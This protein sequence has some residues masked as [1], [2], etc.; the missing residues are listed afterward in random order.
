MCTLTQFCYVAGLVLVL[1][2]YITFAA[3][4]VCKPANAAVYSSLLFTMC[5]WV[6]L[7]VCVYMC[8]CA[9]VYM[10]ASVKLFMYVVAELCAL[11][12]F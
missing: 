12:Q 2:P 9:H 8:V 10:H 7:C 1:I 3:I 11:A 5:L 4:Q 6:C